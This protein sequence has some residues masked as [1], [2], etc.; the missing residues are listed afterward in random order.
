MRPRLLLLLIAASLVV[1]FSLHAPSSAIAARPATAKPHKTPSPE[2][3][4]IYHASVRPLCSALAQHVKTVIGMM[5][6]ND[7]TI[8]KSPPLLARYNRDLADVNSNGGS[9]N[10]AERDLTLYH[11]EQLVGPLANNVNAMEHELEDTTVFPDDPESSDDKQLDAMRDELM[12]ALAVQAV[13]LDIINGY[14]Q[15]QQLAEMQQQGLQDSNQNAISGTDMANTP[16]PTT[17]DPL[18]VDQHQAGLQQ[19]PYAFDPLAVPGITGSV[20][21]TPVTRLISAMHWLQQETAR[22]EGLAAQT[23]VTAANSCKPHPMPTPHRPK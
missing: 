22:R 15:T 20:G 18:L 10:D 13:S 4:V 19:S 2:P 8:A 3:S 5:M 21:T 23:I 11:L 7:Q 14:V 6:Q 12:K 1:A 17:P 9:D 16:V